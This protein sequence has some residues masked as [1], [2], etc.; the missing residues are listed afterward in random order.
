LT[1]HPDF[2]LLSRV[3]RD[4]VRRVLERNTLE[5]TSKKNHA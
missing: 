3:M 2:A 1:R 4:E 5:I